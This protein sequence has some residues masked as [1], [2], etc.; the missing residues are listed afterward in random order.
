MPLAPNERV[1][2]HP[3]GH[4][5]IERLPLPV[6]ADLE[7]RFA[8]LAKAYPVLTEHASHMD[9]EFDNALSDLRALTRRLLDA[10]AE[11]KQ[12]PANLRDM[13]W[14][15]GVRNALRLLEAGDSTAAFNVLE[16]LTVDYAIERVADTKPEH[17]TG[18]VGRALAHHDG[19]PN[20]VQ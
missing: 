4:L 7:P 18:V 16:K 17:S 13:S 19:E 15:S 2:R 20:D 1:A 11:S 12:L 14:I 6:A 8:S 5:I 3:N 10:I 9:G